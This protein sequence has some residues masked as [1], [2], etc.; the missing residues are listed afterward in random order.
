MLTRYWYPQ[1]L[2]TFINTYTYSIGEWKQ[3]IGRNGWN[4][5]Y[6][7]KRDDVSGGVHTRQPQRIEI[8]ELE[9]DCHYA[10]SESYTMSSAM[11]VDDQPV[12]QAP[13]PAPQDEAKGKGKAKDLEK[14]RF[15]VKKV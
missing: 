11:D 1:L 10:I 13:A 4:I 8:A 6:G 7:R 2:Y 9:R 5:W 14:K 3:S 12:A 15:E